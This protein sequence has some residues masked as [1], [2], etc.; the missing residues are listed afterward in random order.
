MRSSVSGP[1]VPQPAS[2]N[3]SFQSPLPLHRPVDP[4]FQS[5]VG[6]RPPTP[7]YTSPAPTNYRS[8]QPQSGLSLVPAE[9]WLAMVLL[10]IAVY[11]VVF[12]IISINQVV[13]G[14]ILFASTAIGLFVGLLVAKLRH[15]PQVIMHLGACL[16]GHWLS[17]FFVSALAFHVSWIELLGD[18]RAV[19]TGGIANAASPDG[20]VFLFYLCFL[21]FFLGYFGAWLVYRAHLPWLVALVYCSILL[22]NLSYAKQD[23]SFLVV[24]LLT[25]LI[26]LI[27]R[28]QLAKQ[29]AGWTSEGLHTDRRWLQ[30]I[31]SRFVRIS[32]VLAVIA[33]LVS[34]ILPALGQPA[35]GQS[36]WN[37]LN[38]F[39][40]NITHGQF[41]FQDPGQPNQLPPSTNFFGDSLTITGNVNLPAGEIL[42]YT[43]SANQPQ[44]LEGFT[45]DHFDGHTWTSAVS[46]ASQS[47]PA[48]AAIPPNLPGNA[49][50]TTT[51]VTIEQPPVGTKNYIFAP[52]EPTSFNVNTTLY[53]TT[54]TSAWTQSAALTQ[55][56]Q[57]QVTSLIPSA[58][59]ENLSSVPLPGNNPNAW[60]S[61]NNYPAL[62]NYLQTPQDLAPTVLATAQQ[63]TKD[64]TNAFQ[65]AY[66]LQSH[67]ND[68]T[69]F[70]YS[71]TNPPVPSNVDAV[72]WLLQ[73][74]QG[75]CTYY[76]TA[77]IVMARLLG[78]P[79]R[80]VNGFS[81]GHFD[82]QRKVWAVDGSDAHSW[83]QVYFPGYG[84]ISFDPTP[85]Y[86]A[87]G[88]AQPQPVPTP[89]PTQHPAKPTPTGSKNGSHPST[90]N[91]VSGASSAPLAARARWSFLLELSL[92]L[93][94]CLVL[95]LCVAIYR[96][97][98]P[99][100]ASQNSLV[101]RAYWRVCRLATWA[102]FA[103][104]RWQTPY[105]Y[106]RAL[107][108]HF[109]QVTTSV[110]WLTDLYVRERWASPREMP[111]PAE[112]ANLERLWPSLRMT[113]LRLFFLRFTR[114]RTNTR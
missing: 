34:L 49:T 106:S 81:Q 9:G 31:T 74:R 112:Q 109:P 45:F 95:A 32:A 86:A 26:L 56:E 100:L 54:F 11:S 10:A 99:A 40:T 79:A 59:A 3:G 113:F 82:A 77:M 91:S 80:L 16:L 23:Q 28:V 7:P 18:L 29:L 90:P 61:D 22:I 51:T 55:G 39:W 87:S 97:R 93:L 6:T 65:A 96:Y 78:I 101:S 52:Y 72:T 84:W 71:L 76:A 42:S 85:G 25:A 62:Q 83:V 50:Q 114:G 68:S 8:R 64:A 94:F 43:T 24:V 46:N 48:E 12:S 63:W 58:T 98:R 15:L 20:I 2:N 27:A 36:F 103:P 53:G 111:H 19:I 13:Q 37:N 104:Q 4:R 1:T 92:A 88:A 73:T 47:Y 69:Q 60:S 30:N 57:Y 35:S 14:S 105:E 107:A 44:Y 66:M 110:R 75:Y 17:V 41:S 67:L 33:L 108:R 38:T 5:R 70:S 21:S 102:G 89:V